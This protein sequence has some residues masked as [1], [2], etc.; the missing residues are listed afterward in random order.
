VIGDGEATDHTDALL[1]ALGASVI[2]II[3][4]AAVG[5]IWTVRHR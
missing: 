2:V 5:V 3:L 4:A 1:L